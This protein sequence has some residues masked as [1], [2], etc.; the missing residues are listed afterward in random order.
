VRGQALATVARRLPH[1]VAIEVSDRGTGMT[2][3]VL[4]NALLPFYSTK[5][6]GLTVAMILPS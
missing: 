2:D 6:G 1:S 3:A 5:R 4:A